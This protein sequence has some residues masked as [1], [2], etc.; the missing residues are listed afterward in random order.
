MAI[1]SKDLINK[2]ISKSDSF[3]EVKD[4]LLKRLQKIELSIFDD[5]SSV[6]VENDL[7]IQLGGGTCLGYVR[8]NGFIPWDDDIDLNMQRKYV[9]CFLKEFSLKHSDKYDIQY[10][11]DRQNVPFVKIRKK[12]TI[13]TE[14]DDIV[15]NQGI[16]IDIFIIEDLPNN[17]IAKN[18][19]GV[20]CTAKLFIASCS[21]FYTNKNE[22]FIDTMA[23][24]KELNKNYRFKYFIGSIFRNKT[25]N[26]RVIDND[27]YF[28]K[29]LGS[30]SSYVVIPTGR[31]HFFGE[32]YKRDIFEDVK[33]IKFLGVKCWISNRYDEY[34]R[35]LYGDNYM[36]IP[37]IEKREHH[38]VVRIEL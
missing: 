34:M 10:K 2:R 32:L 14:L 1:K 22:Y 20:I 4:D 29:Y 36:E 8:H 12:D 28:S 3:I 30:N 17:V 25:Y 6:C 35:N 9:D 11:N 26:K 33:E 13:L 37:P 23:S 27:K 21:A 18:I 19:Y 16:S 15:P 5:V 7:I 24:D 38:H 31:K